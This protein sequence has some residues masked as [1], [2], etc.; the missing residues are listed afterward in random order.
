MAG[1]THAELAA[2]VQA[3]KHMLTAEK[4]PVK[5]HIYRDLANRFERKAGA[6]ERR[7]QNISA[8]YEEHGLPWVPGL[9]PQH[10]IG[11][12]IKTILI[13]M[14][15]LPAEGPS[16][17][18]ELDAAQS[19]AE[20][21][22][23]FDP[24]NVEDARK[25]VVASIVRRQGQ[26]A[27]RKRL[28]KAYSETCVITGCQQVAVLEAAHIHPYRGKQTHAVSNGLL[29]R[30]DLHTL[31]DLY[32]IAI[33]PETRQVRLAPELGQSDYARYEGQPLPDPRSPSA[34]ASI[35][36]LQWH[37]VRCAW[38]KSPSASLG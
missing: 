22:N 20:H 2:S 33:D 16:V 32:L 36:S 30:A 25:R 38:L 6:Y 7:M 19:E 5:A 18:Q 11:S 31:F 26:A 8:I 14:L 3:Y 28:L 15:G 1:W 4:P 13:Q 37:A 35:G 27:F 10:H 24:I 34:M 23:A 17:V 21:E 12:S 29:L 9:K